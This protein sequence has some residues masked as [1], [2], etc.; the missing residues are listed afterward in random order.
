MLDQ[1]GQYLKCAQFVFQSL[2]IDLGKR[3]EELT[4]RDR[5]QK[6]NRQTTQF[7]IYRQSDHY[8]HKLSLHGLA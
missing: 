7:Y 4:V 5:Y 6:R 2:G 3:L 8:S 1:L